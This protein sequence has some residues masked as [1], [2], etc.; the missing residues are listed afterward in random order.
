MRRGQGLTRR[1][2]LRSAAIGGLLGG[3]SRRTRWDEA[4]W[5]SPAPR[6]GGSIVIAIGADP[7]TL[8]PHFTTL[9]YT[10]MIGMSVFSS[11]IRLDPAMQPHPDLAES[12]QI[13]PDY[14]TYTFKLVRNARWHDGKPFTSGDVKFSFEEVARKLNASG[15]LVFGHLLGVD[16]PDA[17]TAVFRFRQPQPALMLY[18]DV[19]LAGTVLPQHIYK[20]TD[21]RQNPANARPIGTGPFRFAAWNRGT[22]V[23]LERNP[24]YFRGG[25]PY[26]DRA[27][28]QVVRDPAAR[29]VALGNR[30]VDLILGYDLA[31]HDTIPLRMRQDLRIVFTIDSAISGQWWIG[32]NNS[33]PPFKDIRVRQAVAYAINKNL[34]WQR[35]FFGLGKIATGPTS[36]Y[37]GPQ[38]TRN[39]PRLEYNPRRANQLL[40][41]A[42]YPRGTGGLRFRTR[43]TFDGT[44]EEFSRIADILKAEL[45]EIGIEVTLE[46]FDFNTWF[47]RVYVKHDY[48]M[49]RGRHI[50]GP[51]AITSMRIEYDSKNTGPGQRNYYFYGNPDVDRLL[52]AGAVETEPT[53]R[54]QMAHRLQALIAGDVPVIFLMD[55]PQP[56]A[57]RSVLR[58]L[59]ND[60]YGVQRLGDVWMTA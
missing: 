38:Y 25:L 28:F 55:T 54:L 9:P 52:E 24:G 51:D 59:D 40:D 42:G 48:E 3:V 58:G 30:D 60:A 18:L 23:T 17:S 4:A 29:V 8:N 56:N 26:L 1:E 37:L 34:I 7:P 21:V 44:S 12:W 50:T 43:F 10:W 2:F 22:S 49:A 36:Q 19:P 33:K 46:S 14:R 15:P 32:L 45:A 6:R 5:A 35:V 31:L 20:G 27:V 11:L 39:V 16:T 47:D 53:K 41:E 13:S 57:Y